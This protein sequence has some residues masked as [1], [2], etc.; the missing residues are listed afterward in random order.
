[1]SLFP[2]PAAHFG[3]LPRSQ[4]ATIL[5]PFRSRE[6]S[7]ISGLSPLRHTSVLL[8]VPCS[9]LYGD[10]CLWLEALSIDENPLIDSFRFRTRPALLTSLDTESKA[11]YIF[12]WEVLAAGA[13][14]G[15]CPLLPFSSDTKSN[16]N[17]PSIAL[18]LVD[19]ICVQDYTPFPLFFL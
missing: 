19:G 10:C 14:K 11:N 8:S 4:T 13:V 6:V 1:M 7:G 9:P 18:T 3:W 2:H 16:E 12:D 17:D 15:K 5:I